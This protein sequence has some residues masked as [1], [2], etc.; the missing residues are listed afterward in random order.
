MVRTIMGRY[1]TLPEPL[2]AVIGI[3]IPVPVHPPAK[4]TDSIIADRC[5]FRIFPDILEQV[6]GRDRCRQPKRESVGS[7]IGNDPFPNRGHPNQWRVYR[8]NEAPGW[9]LFHSIH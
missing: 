9:Q 6:K 8:R 4:M 7:H 5:L 1:R 2:A 3:V